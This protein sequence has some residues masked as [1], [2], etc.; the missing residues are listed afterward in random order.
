MLNNLKN[1]PHFFTRVEVNSK[2]NPAASYPRYLD[3]LEGF[4]TSRK[5]LNCYPQ[6]TS[7]TLQKNYLHIQPHFFHLGRNFLW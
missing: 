2:E 4:K 7:K 3:I 5:H 1:Q 6:Y